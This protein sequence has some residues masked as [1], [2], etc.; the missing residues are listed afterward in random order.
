MCTIENKKIILVVYKLI[1]KEKWIGNAVCS[2]EYK[3]VREGFQNMLKIDLDIT[4][5]QKTANTPVYKNFEFEIE[6]IENSSQSFDLINKYLKTMYL[7][8]E[9][10][11]VETI[12]EFNFVRCIDNK[13]RLTLIGSNMTPYEISSQKNGKCLPLS[14]INEKE[15]INYAYENFL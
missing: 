9:I 2:Y 12:F 8:T 13:I 3:T 11:L 4:Y 1:F 14:D 5:P 15:S 10:V 6:C 7:G